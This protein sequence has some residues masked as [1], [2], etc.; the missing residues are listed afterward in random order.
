[1]PARRKAPAGPFRGS[2]RLNG[3]TCLLDAFDHDRLN[4]LQV[5]VLGSGYVPTS[6]AARAAPSSRI[7]IE[8]FRPDVDIRLAASDLL[9]HLCPRNR[10][11]RDSG[12]MAARVPVLVPDCGG[13][14]DL[15]E[16]REWLSVHG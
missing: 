3:S 2:I 10:R 12:A 9:V 1:L 16:R 5:Q 4:R 15:V 11:T 6:Y 7:R 13:A 8:G 14:G